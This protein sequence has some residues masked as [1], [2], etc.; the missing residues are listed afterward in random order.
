LTGYKSKPLGV[1]KKPGL[2]AGRGWE[3]IDESNINWMEAWKGRSCIIV[4]RKKSKGK[5]SKNLIHIKGLHNTY[6]YV[7]VNTK[8]D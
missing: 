3:W 5:M 2:E 4:F 8:L 7:L 1:I 6:V